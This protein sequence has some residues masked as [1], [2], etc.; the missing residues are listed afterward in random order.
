MAR[1]GLAVARLALAMQPHAHHV[2]V[3]AGPGNNGGDGLV[4]A[5]H[6]FAAGKRVQVNLVGDPARLPP[7]AALAWREAAAAG[8]GLQ[9]WSGALFAPQQRTDLVIDALLGLGAARAVSGDMAQAID[10]INHVDAPVLAVDI[11]S[12]LDPDTGAALGGPMVR[13]DKTLS[14]LTLKP[15]CFTAEGRDH[16]GQV[17]LDT[18]GALAGQAT[19]Y[20]PGA[21]AERPRSHSSHKGRHGDVAV[22]GGASGMVGAAWLAAR[23][24]LAAGA[25]RVFVSLLDEVAASYDPQRPELMA[26]RHW[27]RSP[28]EVLGLSTVVCGCGAGDAL[29]EV[30]PP[31]LAHAARLV[32]DADALNAVAADASLMAALRRRSTRA[33]G[34]VLTP[35]PLEAARLLGRTTLQV[36]HDRLGAALTLAELSG[37]TV[38]L[39]GSGSV[40]ARAGDLPLINPTGN[41][42]LA[43]GGTGDVLAGWIGGLWAQDDAPDALT[44]ASAATWRHGQAA[45]RFAALKG[46]GPLRAADLVEW[47]AGTRGHPA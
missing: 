28:P 30:L 32:L 4:A 27:W 47:M 35:H 41:G 40:L 44:V 1:A 10:M 5:R 22:V 7:D 39:K 33:M 13:A 29:R 24:A 37:A 12:G 14:L 15:G 17:W 16:A 42:A 31:L 8:V 45:D 38:V 46:H 6:L 21:P 36:Q 34:T 25:G 23:A 11:P 26:R 2:T 19:A 18:L 43:T 20:L 3:L 9:V